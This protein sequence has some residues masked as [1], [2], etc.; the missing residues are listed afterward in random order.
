[1]DL[2]FT[3]NS[4]EAKISSS[5]IQTFAKVCQKEFNEYTGYNIEFSKD[6][7]LY[8][9][10][11]QVFGVYKVDDI[12]KLENGMFAKACIS[13]DFNL[14]FQV[15]KNKY[16]LK[17]YQNEVLKL[18]IGLTK[19]QV[20]AI[21]DKYNIDLFDFESPDSVS[22]NRF[23]IV[24][25]ATFMYKDKNTNNLGCKLSDLRL[26]KIAHTKEEI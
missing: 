12:L 9:I 4:N 6:F 21:S 18:E 11:Q 14:N 10:K 22:I 13:D 23:R 5:N 17:C 3:K 2:I 16:F 15:I 25:A 20:D 24:I 8:G 26:I 1:M 19:G 7:V